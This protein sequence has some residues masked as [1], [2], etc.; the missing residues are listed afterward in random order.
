M[1]WGRDRFRQCTETCLRR[2][3]A[4]ESHSTDLLILWML[5]F[6]SV[7][8]FVSSAFKSCVLRERHGKCL[9]VEKLCSKH[10][11]KMTMG[12]RMEEGMDGW[13]KGWMDGDTVGEN[14]G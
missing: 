11:V 5:P 4:E 12:R 3:Q 2:P 10:L 7:F 13:R 6:K 14:K 9:I 1:G 8:S